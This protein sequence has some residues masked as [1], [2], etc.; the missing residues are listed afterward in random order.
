MSNMRDS[1]WLVENVHEDSML[2]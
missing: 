2:R 1:V